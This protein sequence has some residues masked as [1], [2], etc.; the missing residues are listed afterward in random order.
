MS[1]SVWTILNVS[2]RIEFPDL[3]IDGLDIFQTHKRL[4]D[5]AGDLQRRD[6]FRNRSHIDHV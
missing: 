1:S 2:H 5:V 6:D 3:R 4:R